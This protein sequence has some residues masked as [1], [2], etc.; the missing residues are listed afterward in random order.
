MSVIATWHDV[1]ADAK[2]EFCERHSREP[3]PEPVGTPACRRPE[4]GSS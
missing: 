4:W 1:R 2:E 3:L